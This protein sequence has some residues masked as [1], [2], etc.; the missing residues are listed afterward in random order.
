MKRPSVFKKNKWSK[1]NKQRYRQ[2]IA[3]FQNLNFNKIIFMDQT[4]FDRRNTGRKK[5]RARRGKPAYLPVGGIFGRHYTLAGMISLSQA[6]V[7]PIVYNLINGSG[8]YGS[9]KD[10]MYAAV[11][12]GYVKHGDI[13]ICDNW[14]GYVGQ[15]C[16]EKLRNELLNEFNGVGTPR[17]LFTYGT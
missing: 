10:F 13:I 15:H 7:R 16:G 3:T 11:Q 17:Q 14:S 5:I 6:R 1:R 9:Y 12:S 2:F 8:T 4:G